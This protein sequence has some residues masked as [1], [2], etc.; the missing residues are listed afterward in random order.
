LENIAVNND[1]SA[2]ETALA[3]NAWTRFWFTPIPTTGMQCLRFLAGLLFF[4]W[5]ASFLGHQVEI[6]SLNGWLDSDAF[7]EMRRQGDLAPVPIG[8]SMLYLAEDS[9]PLFQAM[10]FGSLAVFVLFALGVATR[11]TGVLTWVIVVSFFANP[12]TSYEGDYLLGI[13][14]F[15]LMIGHLLKGLGPV[16]IGY[17]MI[18]SFAAMLLA[19]ATTL[20]VG[21][22]FAAFGI[23][24]LFV[25]VIA[26]LLA[27]PLD[28]HLSIAERFL[29]SRHDFLLARWLFP[30]TARECPQSCSANLMMRMLQIHFV[31]IIMVSALH[32]LQIADWWAGVALWYPLH[33]TFKTTAESLQR[34]S[35][36]ADFTLFYLSAAQYLVLAWQL[37]LPIFAWRTGTAW[38]SLLLGGAA[39]S[40]L[41]AF[42]LFQLPLF[43]PFVVLGCLSFLRPE[44]WAWIMT[45]VRSRF[46]G[47]E[48]RK[49][50][51]EAKKVAVVAGKDNIKK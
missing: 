49:V 50:E 29:G 44:E 30:Q 25:L 46:G 21:T 7:K 2:T 51:P 43:G 42:F 47:I 10:Y 17:L 11:I 45:A 20:L 34:E 16:R 12:V 22:W 8:W 31:I 4:A 26:I 24:G 3:D 40:W 39:V 19:L 5:L 35:A 14:A 27:I 15:Y 37:G 18:A 48:K 9:I 32:K 33:P 41:G 13:L 23:G 28:D 36:N 6:F 1:R 38:R